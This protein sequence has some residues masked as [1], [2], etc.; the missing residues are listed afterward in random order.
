MADQS[1]HN[2]SWCSSFS[3]RGATCRSLPPSW[4]GAGIGCLASRVPW[5]TALDQKGICFGLHKSLR[6]Y[7]NLQHCINPLRPYINLQHC[8]NPLRPCIN[9]LRLYKPPPSCMP[10]VQ[11]SKWSRLE[12]FLIRFWGSKTRD[13]WLRLLTHKLDNDYASKDMASTKS[14]H[15]SFEWFESLHTVESVL[16][17]HGLK[18]W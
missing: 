6:P 9:P 13:I 14:I 7:I 5:W 2:Q 3:R 8:I 1:N 11:K 4:T 18:K 10:L 15:G 16:H 12:W 17:G